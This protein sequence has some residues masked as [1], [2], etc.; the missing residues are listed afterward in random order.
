[1]GRGGAA[2]D[3]REAVN[4]LSQSRTARRRLPAACKRFR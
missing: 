1:M 4:T 3:H 2:S